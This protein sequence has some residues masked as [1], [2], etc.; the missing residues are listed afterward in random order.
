MDFKVLKMHVTNL[1]NISSPIDRDV[2]INNL[3]GLGYDTYD[4]K[5]RNYLLTLDEDRFI[6]I[7]LTHVK[8]GIHFEE[9]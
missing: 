7:T 6:D 5:F 2:F 8:K 4:P 1:M 3:R 9:L